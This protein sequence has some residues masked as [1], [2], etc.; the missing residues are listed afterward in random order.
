MKIYNSYHPN[1]YLLVITLLSVSQY[2][3]FKWRS[4][5]KIICCGLT[6]FQLMFQKIK[7]NM[8]NPCEDTINPVSWSK[9]LFD[10]PNHCSHW[11]CSSLVRLGLRALFLCC[12]CCYWCLV[13]LLSRHLH[14]AFADGQ[15]ISQLLVLNLNRTVEWIV[16]V[17]YIFIPQIHFPHI[18]LQLWETWERRQEEQRF[19]YNIFCFVYC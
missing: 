15:E 3:V 4:L 9:G 13:A 14:R 11:G 19:L 6:E 8:V 12:C 16:I 1:I 7:Q 18:F 10:A 5:P 2:I 17:I